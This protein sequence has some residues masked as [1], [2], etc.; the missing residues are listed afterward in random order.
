MR[1]SIYF[2]IAATLIVFGCAAQKTQRDRDVEQC[3]Y[4]AVVPRNFDTPAKRRQYI[5]TVAVPAC[6]KAKGYAEGSL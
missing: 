5:Q 1:A 3:T 4:G 2:L 6:L